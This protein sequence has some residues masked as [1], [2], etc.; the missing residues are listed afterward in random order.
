M[1]LRSIATATNTNFLEAMMPPQPDDPAE[2]KK[3]EQLQ[4]EL[5]AKGAHAQVKDE[6]IRYSSIV[7]LPVKKR[8]I[9]TLDKLIRLDA[10]LANHTR[11]KEWA[12][13][14]M[15]YLQI[16]EVRKENP[17]PRMIEKLDNLAKGVQTESLLEAEIEDPEIAKAALAILQSVD[18]TDSQWRKTKKGSIQT[19]ELLALQTIL[20]QMGFDVGKADGWFGKR[21]ARGVMAFQR[22]HDLTVDGDPGKNTIA[23]MIE[24]ANEFIGE[25]DPERGTV[26]N[27][28][29]VS[30]L[31]IGQLND[32]VFKY[33]EE[34]Y[35][36]L[37]DTH[38]VAF[39]SDFGNRDRDNLLLVPFFPMDG[40][41]PSNPDGP[42][43]TSQGIPLDPPEDAED[44]GLDTDAI[45]K[46]IDS[47]DETDKP[48]DD[49]EASKDDG[50][51]DSEEPSSTGFKPNYNGTWRNDRDQF[52]QTEM[53][54]T[55]ARELVQAQVT[56]SMSRS[57]M[58]DLRGEITRLIDR[59]NNGRI[60]TN[61]KYPRSGE[62][63]R[64]PDTVDVLKRY[65]DGFLMDAIRRG[66]EEPE[67]KEPETKEPET[68]P[69]TTTDTS[70]NDNQSAA[71]DAQGN[72]TPKQSTYDPAKELDNLSTEQAIE[73]V[74]K[75]IRA[76]RY[77]DALAAIDYDMRIELN[78]EMYKAL[79]RL[80]DREKAQRESLEE[81]QIWARS[82]QKVVRKYRCTAGIRKGRIVSQMAQ[83]FA[84]PDLKKR[85]SLKRTKAR[86][87]GRMVR[88]AKR[89]KRVN[90]ASRR[91]QALNRGK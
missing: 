77:V 41:P 11:K 89:T 53:T 74:R 5:W 29:E 44:G 49:D 67:T 18:T 59:L 46:A 73:E 48:E 6:Y 32:Y 45:N 27:P 51:Q 30:R 78:A 33:S 85:F 47:G 9:E 60:P 57:D 62:I 72:A 66:A 38:E 83:C 8:I 68:P 34:K 71:D 25:E 21:T 1:R 63:V 22:E 75:L 88:K 35:E 86:L 13:T 31:I 24:V 4:R 65:R 19:E 81:K 64:L 61:S 37:K 15:V 39:I 42:L 2:A 56:G 17:D 55:D 26:D 90:P 80:A 52:F 69:E 7:G 54:A 58:F 43:F 50:A 40:T 91:V 79:I 76:K 16:K 10:V 84:A 23:K 36:E 28:K 12:K 3:S 87:G 82:G 20:N 70:A 14:K